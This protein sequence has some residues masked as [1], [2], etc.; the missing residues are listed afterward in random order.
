MKKV[1]LVMVA[2]ITLQ[3]SAQEN[4]ER[5][6]DH[7]KE[8]FKDLKPEQIATLKSKNMMLHLDLT[9]RQYNE[10]YLLNLELAKERKSKGSERLSK[11]E[12]HKLSAE[13]KYNHQIQKLDKQ[14]EIKKRFAKILTPEQMEKFDKMQMHRK[15]MMKRRIM[16]GKKMKP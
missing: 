4:D 16:K 5:R 15:S 9:D 12:R 1:I 8:F 14:I 13:D 11:E 3:L 10:V 7:H 2:L 6:E